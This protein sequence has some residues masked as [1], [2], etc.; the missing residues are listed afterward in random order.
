MHGNLG[1]EL[2]RKHRPGLILL[3]LHLPDLTGREVLERLQ[4]DPATAAIPVVVLSADATANQI[5]R[6]L[7]DG[8]ADYLTKPVDLP[9]LLEIVSEAG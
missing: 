8:A 5:E 4:A 3:D 9:R 6:L 7:K 1:L 2:A